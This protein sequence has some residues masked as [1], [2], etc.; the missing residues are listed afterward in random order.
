M[1][2]SW[3]QRKYDRSHSETRLCTHCGRDR[4]ISHMEPLYLPE[5]GDPHKLTPVGPSNC[6]TE[7]WSAFLG[8]HEFMRRPGNFEYVRR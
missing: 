7:C 5:V 6:C 2:S 3:A 4:L 8:R 1:P